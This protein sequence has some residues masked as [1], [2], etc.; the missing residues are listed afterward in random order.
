MAEYIEREAALYWARGGCHPANVA[1]EIE[2]IPAADVIDREAAAQMLEAEADKI[3]GTRIYN[4][5]R[6]GAL[7]SAAGMIR[8]MGRK[9]REEGG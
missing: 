4:I 1:A 7:R 8:Q 2:K 5:T 3:M 6:A 9:R